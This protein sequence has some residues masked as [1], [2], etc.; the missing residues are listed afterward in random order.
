MHRDAKLLP[1][2][3]ASPPLYQLVVRAL[4][5]EILRGIYPVGG[6]LPSEHALVARFGVSRHTVREALRHLRDL[7]LVES[8]QGKGTSVL[9]PGAP[10]VYV[11][12][13][14]SI[15]DL[16]D[17]NVES[18][19]SDHSEGL[20]L[21]KAAA[22]RI[23]GQVGETWLRID[24]T[25]FDQQSGEAICS[26]EIFVPPWF[27]GI[28][29]LLGRSSGPIYGLIEDVHGESIGEVSQVVRAIPA[30]PAVA[31]KLG[32]LADETTMEIQ[33]VYRCL[34]GRVAEV[35]FNYYKASTFSLSMTMKRVRN[36]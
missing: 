29:R 27:A 28:G 9:K 20:R 33:R 16:H 34:D 7:G 15:S 22:L 17:F 1:E 5:S 19:Y 35:T 32:L 31:E 36:P 12:Q 14:N 18:R 26:V 23:G 11:H 13:I 21:N 4:R 8:R 6:S 2:E 24:G 30:P 10:Q 3:L 25:R